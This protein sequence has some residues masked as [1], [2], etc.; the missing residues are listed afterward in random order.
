MLSIA[1]VS[2]NKNKYSETFIHRQVALLPADVHLLYGGYLPVM[3]GNDQPLALEMGW[4]HRIFG[5]SQKQAAIL[6]AKGI[7]SYL[8][9]NKIQAVLAQYGPSGVAMMEICRKIGIPL[10]VHFHG[11]DA[12]RKDILQDY[13]GKYPALF[14]TANTVCVSTDM[15]R[16]LLKLGAD[17][18]RL[19]LIPYGVDTDLF[20]PGTKKMQ[21]PVFIA[22]G[23]FV[24]KKAPHLTIEAFAKTLEKIP[25]A[26]LMMIGE[27]EMLPACRSLADSLGIS[28]AIDFKGVMGQAE[29]AQLLP[30][31][32][33]LV[34]HS[35]RSSEGDA[36]G[37]PLAILEAGACGLPVVATKHMGISDAVVE[38]ETG[39]LVAE[40]DTVG[41]SNQM[42]YLAQNPALAS[43]MGFAARQRICIHYNQ[44]RYINDLW[45]TILNAIAG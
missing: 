4:W 28:H 40:G 18:E 12:Y 33:A 20:K 29:V 37:L 27:G 9:K 1:I 17:P 5:L 19:H 6:N 13:G 21:H 15:Q 2:N 10:I 35:V 34:Q 31:A 14:E 22:C 24:P 3:F 42:V 25:N 26:K 30:Q 43:T 36:E 8:L 7:E 39:F 38:G 32:L 11:F 23:R 16:Q 45:A 44:E 41:M